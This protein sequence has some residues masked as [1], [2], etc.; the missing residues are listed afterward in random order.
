LFTVGSDCHRICELGAGVFRVIENVS[1]KGA[2]VFGYKGRRPYL[3][4]R[5]LNDSE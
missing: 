2:K 3:I 4:K 1:S 5:V